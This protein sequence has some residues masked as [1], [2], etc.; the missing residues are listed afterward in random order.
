MII[1][2]VNPLELTPKVESM[3]TD[4]EI[5]SNIKAVCSCENEKI[6]HRLR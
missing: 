5:I 3:K 6:I 4:E 1:G 2:F